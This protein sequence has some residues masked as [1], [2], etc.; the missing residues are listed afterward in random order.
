MSPLSK[1]IVSFKA[2]L[3]SESTAATGFIENLSRDNIIFVKAFPVS[4]SL[5]LIPGETVNVKFHSD[6]GKE[7]CL[8]CKV[9]WAFS[10][11]HNLTQNYWLEVADPQTGYEEIFQ[12]I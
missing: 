5:N 1:K 4:K 11:L 6:S 10:P 12:T 2:E 8:N 7:L 3:S 9:K